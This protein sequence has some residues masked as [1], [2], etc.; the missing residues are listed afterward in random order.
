MKVTP[1]MMSKLEKCKSVNDVLELAK[2]E[3]ISLTLE[4]AQK[5][6]ELM[7]SEDVPDEVMENVTGGWEKC[8]TYQPTCP[9]RTR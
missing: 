1:Q 7:K 9:G 6:F 5:A 4:Q 3:N 2:K 8:N